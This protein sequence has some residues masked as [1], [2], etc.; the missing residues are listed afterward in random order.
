MPAPDLPPLFPREAPET[1]AMIRDEPEML[2]FM[3]E[4][5][6]PSMQTLLGLEPYNHETQTGF[7]C[8]SC[9][10]HGGESEPATPEQN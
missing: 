3:S 7:S 5:V 8:F 1:Q 4:S 10:P 2:Q 6:V 9:H